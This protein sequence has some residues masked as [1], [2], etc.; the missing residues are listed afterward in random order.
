MLL[1]EQSLASSR[2]E[3]RKVIKPQE[4]KA[5]SNLHTKKSEAVECAPRRLLSYCRSVYDLK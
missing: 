1:L 5:K 3:P 4:A 2:H